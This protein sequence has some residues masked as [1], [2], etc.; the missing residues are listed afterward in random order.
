MRPILGLLAVALLGACESAPRGPASDDTTISP[1]FSDAAIVDLAVLPAEIHTQADADPGLA[2]GLRSSAH[3]YLIAEKNY[4]VPEDAYVDRAMAS[5]PQGTAPP[6]A[7]DAASADAA[8]LITI[9][10]WDVTELVPK[11]R[12]SADGT[13]QVHGKDGTLYWERRFANRMLLAPHTVT[14]ANRR[15]TVEAMTRVFARDLLAP[16]PPKIRR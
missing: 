6:R 2:A 5:L 13:V 14:A 11:G 7:A 1:R 3:E 8:L 10:R 12:I 15:E 4:S 16:L 9:T